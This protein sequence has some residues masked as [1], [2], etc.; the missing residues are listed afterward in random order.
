MSA[1]HTAE[2]ERCGA[3][4]ADP[5]PAAQPTGPPLLQR[6]DLTGHGEGICGGMNNR[7]PALLMVQARVVDQ[8]GRGCRQSA[9]N[10]DAGEHGGGALGARQAVEPAR[11]HPRTD[12]QL[13]EHRVGGVPER[14]THQHRPEPARPAQDARQPG[15]RVRDRIQGASL[16]QDVD[17]VERLCARS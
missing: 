17:L 13:H 1:E 7:D 4:Q 9:D 10:T 6:R 12:R 16:F 14:L 5:L 2:C 3:G 8:P 11:A 15:E